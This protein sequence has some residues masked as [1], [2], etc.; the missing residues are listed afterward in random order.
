MSPVNNPFQRLLKL[1]LSIFLSSTLR[2]LLV[3]LLLVSC[4]TCIAMSISTWSLVPVVTIPLAVLSVHIIFRHSFVT[5]M[6]KREALKEKPW[7]GTF[8]DFILTTAEC[9]CV[10]YFVRPWEWN[11]YEPVCIILMSAIYVQV[12]CLCLLLMVRLAVVVTQ[13]ID[14]PS[15]VVTKPYDFYAVTKDDK[16]PIYCIVSPIYRIVSGVAISHDQHK[17]V[18]FLRRIFTMVIAMV[19]LAFLFTNIIIEPAQEAGMTPQKIYI[20]PNT[21][22]LNQDIVGENWSIVAFARNYMFGDKSRLHDA[23]NVNAQWDNGNVSICAIRNFELGDRLSNIP[24]NEDNVKMVVFDCPAWA[25]GGGLWPDVLITVNFTTLGINATFPSKSTFRTV[26]IVVGMHDDTLGVIRNTW[27]IPLVPNAHLLGGVILTI[28][29]QFKRP[30]LASL[31]IF[32]SRNGFYSGA[33]PFLWSDP[34]FQVPRDNNTATLRLYLQDDYSDLH[35]SVEYREKS[36]LSGIAA[37]GGF[38]TVLNGLFATIFGTTLL[39]VLVG[40][41]PLSTFGLI[42][43]IPK[44]RPVR[45][46][47]RYRNLLSESQ[48][49][50]GMLD[51]I[52]DHFVDL[53]PFEDNRPVNEITNPGTSSPD[54]TSHKMNE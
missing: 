15:G 3:L 22:A 29:E 27:P 44:F 36:V 45:A 39:F 19:L 49:D 52:H 31:G 32:S 8:V 9:T 40:S 25:L 17:F 2:I 5:V 51:Y 35:L 37:V 46:D 42:H 28:R 30:G 13:A 47:E 54:L 48:S 10:L 33:I 41:K 6:T 4:F 43:K 12:A 11:P 7:F 14:K 50:K 18:P 26:S 21:A 20:T 1:I 16:S 23:I 34:S 38:W 24:F 53:G